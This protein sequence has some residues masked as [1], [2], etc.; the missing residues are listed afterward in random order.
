MNVC[1]FL[2]CADKVRKFAAS[3]AEDEK[4]IAKFKKDENEKLKVSIVD[5][6]LSMYVCMYVCT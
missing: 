2:L 6:I 3:I 4:L 5:I 1:L